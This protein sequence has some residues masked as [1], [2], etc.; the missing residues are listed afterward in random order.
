[1][2]HAPDPVLAAIQAHKTA[3][4]AY[5][6]AIDRN[7]AVGASLPADKRRSNDNRWEEEIYET[8]DP[9]WIESE[10]EVVRTSSEADRLAVGLL[11]IVPTTLIGLIAIVEYAVVH[12][13]D[14]VHWPDNLDDD[15]TQGRQRSWQHFLLQ[16]V[17]LVALRE[18]VA[19]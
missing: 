8:D 9:R 11:S 17:V 6:A 18:G 7:E 16:N 19:A 15:D 2:G 13:V 1:M 12:D 10:R 4:D 5:G 14:G 3:Y